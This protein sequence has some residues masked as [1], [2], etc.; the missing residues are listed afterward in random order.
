[1]LSGRI[2]VGW[3]SVWRGGHVGVAWGVMKKWRLEYPQGP[4]VVSRV[5]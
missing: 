3:G 2:V 5:Y 4:R 1:M